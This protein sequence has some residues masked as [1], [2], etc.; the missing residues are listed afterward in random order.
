MMN[1]I[2]ISLLLIGLHAERVTCWIQ[3]PETAGKTCNSDEK[4]NE[5]KRFRNLSC[6]LLP[7]SFIMNVNSFHADI[8]SPLWQQNTSFLIFS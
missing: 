8:F 4:A 6:C 2:Y 5:K 7:S 1:W 3:A